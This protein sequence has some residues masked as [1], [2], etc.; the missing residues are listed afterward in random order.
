M[1][2]RAPRRGERYERW[3]HAHAVAIC[4]HLGLDPTRLRIR[5]EVRLE[6]RLRYRV[7]V[8][9]ESGDDV[10]VF[11]CKDSRPSPEELLY[12]N[13]RV[14]DLARAMPDR[15]VYGVVMATRAP[16][17]AGLSFFDPDAPV[18]APPPNLAAPMTLF[19]SPPRL[20]GRTLL[21]WKL[22]DSSVE[23]TVLHVGGSIRSLPEI[24]QALAADTTRARLA[25][26]LEAMSRSDARPSL[27]LEAATV[28]ANAFHHLGSGVDTRFAAD[29]A[30]AH[31]AAVGSHA[32]AQEAQVLRTFADYRI[33]L[34]A[35][36]RRMPGARAVRRLDAIL[37][38]LT[39]IHRASA[40]QLI[41]PWRGLHDDAAAGATLLKRSLDVAED[42]REVEEGA[43][44]QFIGRIRLAEIDA[45]D[46]D[47]WLDAAVRLLPTLKP[48]HREWADLLVSRMTSGQ[49]VSIAT[50]LRHR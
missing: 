2:R 22:T 4:T 29:V 25:A 8:L 40:L 50:R 24:E 13:H 45:G 47:A 6:G 39:G 5:R 12:A 43:Y 23:A 11:E 28:A 10:V 49:D 18:L 9:A 14:I 36:R 48:M 44:L 30:A 19:V 21:L 46:R 15:N 31:A 26:A 42:L 27:L 41:G 34:D 20:L 16:N 7:D 37:P 38:D 33:A 17:A 35:G 1:R 32:R 3:V